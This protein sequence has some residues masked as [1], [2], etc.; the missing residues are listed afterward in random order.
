MSTDHAKSTELTH[1]SPS[2][3]SSTPGSISLRRAPLMYPKHPYPP[4]QY[5]NDYGKS[6]HGI[7]S[8]DR[9]HNQHISKPADKLEKARSSLPINS[10]L[11]RF[12]S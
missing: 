4:S 1:K 9:T 6:G 7:K 2:R 11:W 10:A 12:L 3:E 8:R 5:P